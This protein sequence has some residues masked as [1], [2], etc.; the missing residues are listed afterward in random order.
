MIQHGS[1]LFSNAD[2]VEL[3]D[4]RHA[5]HLSPEISGEERDTARRVVRFLQAARPDRIITELGGH[6]V[7]AIFDSGKPGP[8]AMFRCELDALP[9]QEISDSSY[10][11]EV[12]GKGHLCGHDGHMTILAALARA[13]HREPPRHGRAVL[14]FQPAEENGAGAAA[15]IAD[16]KFAEIEPDYAFALHNMPGLPLGFATLSTGPANCASR[17]MRISLSGKT[18]HASV[19]EAGRSPMRAVADLMPALTALGK[20][21]ALDE[22]Y[23]LVTVTHARMGEPAFGIAPGYAEIWATL[24]TLRDEKMDAMCAEAEALVR[25][26]A[27]RCGLGIEITYHDV[28][29]HCDND[30][31]AVKLLRQAFDD[32]GV[33]HG[34]SDP[35]RGSE[36]FGLFGRSA[37]AAMFLFGSGENTPQLHNPDFD[38]PDALIEPG[39]RI[40]MR[41]AANLLG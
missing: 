24:R 1:A 11:S 28:F 29:H 3:I 27:S 23:R 20:G 40:F 18:S 21:G 38:F 13:L 39:A 36:D 41:V 30:A 37:K 33:S 2:I 4:F 10:R 34:E 31:E 7:A 25:E 5:L 9:I 6:G 16:P 14:L 15:V 32:E 17:G 19:P 35:M 12:P 22:N 8:T 26:S